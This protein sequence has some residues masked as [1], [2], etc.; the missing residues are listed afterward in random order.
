M[1][2]YLHNAVGAEE[3]ERLNA[4]RIAVQEWKVL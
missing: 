3:K 4:V 1:G 2:R